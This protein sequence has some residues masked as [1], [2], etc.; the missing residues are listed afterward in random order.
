MQLFELIK[1]GAD[2]YRPGGHPM[3]ALLEPAPSSVEYNPAGQSVDFLNRTK[4][5]RKE[6][7]NKTE[8]NKIHHFT[9]RINIVNIPLQFAS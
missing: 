3:Q 5:E 4:M 6:E 9:K 2:E 8:T 1:P 7:K